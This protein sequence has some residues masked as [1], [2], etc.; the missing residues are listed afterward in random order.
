MDEYEQRRILVVEDNDELRATMSDLLRWQGYVV[1]EA[2]HGAEALS[3]AVAARPDLIVTD[4]DMPVMDGATF[5]QCCRGISGL[6]DVPIVVMSAQAEPEASTLQ[7]LEPAPVRAY[8]AKPFGVEELTEAIESD[9][10]A[11]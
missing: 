6:D 11:R 7:R 5:I 9:T 8:L 2:A 10:H 4:L 3:V 1:N